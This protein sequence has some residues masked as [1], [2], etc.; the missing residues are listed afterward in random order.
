MALPGKGG[1]ISW[2]GAAVAGMGEWNLDINVDTEEI[3]NFASNGWK[4]YLATLKSWTGSCTGTYESA[5]AAQDAMIT[6]ITGTGAAAAVVFTVTSGVTLSGQAI[7]TAT[8]LPV[9]VGGKVEISFD[10][11]GT[12]ALTPPA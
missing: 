10:M 6:A 2:G 3:T 5:D 12:G 7:L 8:G 1:N 4:E 11:Q 9:Q